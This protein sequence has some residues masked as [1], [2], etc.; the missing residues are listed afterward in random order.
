MDPLTCTDL[1]LDRLEC[2]DGA[3]VYERLLCSPTVICGR[4]V[5][6]EILVVVSPPWI[7]EP[8]PAE[9]LDLQPVGVA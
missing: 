1:T 4:H 5:V 8:P 7:D 9:S 3:G 2:I 6:N